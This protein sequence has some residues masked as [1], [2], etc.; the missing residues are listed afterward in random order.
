MVE[1]LVIPDGA[2]ERVGAGPTSLEAARTPV[3]DA[4]AA[5]GAVSARA[6]TPPGLAAGSETGVATLLGARLTGRPSRG[7]IE[8]AAAGLRVAPGCSAWR[9]DLY[10]YGARFVPAV[11]AQFGEV[12][13]ISLPA[14]EVHHL[15]GHRYLAVG[16]G[17][18]VLHH[19]LIEGRVWGGEG[20]APRA[21]LDSST[22]VVCGPG[23]AAGIGLLMGAAVVIP[24]GATGGP[25]TDLEAK[26]A[27]VLRALD[28]GA[29]RVVVHVGW[30]DESAHEHDRAGKIAALEA[31]DAR[32]LAPL[33]DQALARGI[34]LCVCP[35]HGT[36][37]DTGA[38]LAEP[39]PS[40]RVGVGVAPAGPDRLCERL[41][42]G[43]GVV[44]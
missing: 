2:A 12:L 7:L 33:A 27:A 14:H 11:P 32:V 10:M 18:P 36:D 35:D 44:A 39:V 34:E 23:A 28:E 22:V 9:V 1:I 20:E 41:L 21:T 13:R 16:T 40:L 38:H 17:A 24:A 5:R 15:R 37:P 3:L 43:I 42:A 19:P 26:V 30:P 8:A 31:I 25:G 6:T 4:L 29:R